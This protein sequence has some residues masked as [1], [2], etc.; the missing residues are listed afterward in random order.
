LLF[1]IPFLFSL[2]FHEAAHAYLADKRGDSTAKA[3]GR[4]T[5][6]PLPHIDIFGTVIFPVLGIMF[7]GLLFGWAKPVP[8]NPVNLKNYKKDSML[9]SL[10]G[11]VSN[12]ILAVAFTLLIKIV[13][14]FSP[15]A[16]RMYYSGSVGLFDYPLISILDLG[17]RLNI[18][19]ALFNM[20]PVPPLDGSHVLAGIL[21]DRFSN[22]MERYHQMGFVVFMLL[23]FS[24][25][26]KYLG[27]PIFIIYST[28]L[29]LFL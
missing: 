3:L 28:L 9:I 20:I 29:R 26:L 2:S 8:V 7:G 14:I 25:F 13:A 5:I 6:N 27:Y 21:P 19:L 15:V 16:I 23:L 18:T 17:I 1:S 4:M 10:A 12:I 11:P 24:G 22:F